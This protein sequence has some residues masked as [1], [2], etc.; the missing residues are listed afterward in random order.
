ME[1]LVLIGG[2]GHA[3]VVLDMAE[4]CAELEVVGYFDRDA[5]TSAQL[6]APF[7]G[8]VSHLARLAAQG[9]RKV[10]IAIGDNLLRSQLAEMVVGQGFEL[11]NIVSRHAM[12]SRR[13]ELCTGIAVMPGAIINAYARIGEGCV[14]NTGATVDHDCKI[15]AWA[16]LGPQTGLAGGVEVG[17][18]T[19]M[20]VGVRVIPRISI[21]AWTTVGAGAVVVR[22]L[23]ERVLAVGV[24]ARILR[25]LE[26][27]VG[28]VASG[29]G[30][31]SEA[32]ISP[33]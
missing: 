26:P 11:V 16:H 14:I 15:G 21:G 19:Y 5:G 31:A 3:K 8:D 23:P 25:R 29:I 9:I 7:L 18:G 6:P 30:C 10:F 4:D 32:G 12:V 33:N 17:E 13:A 1:K 24:P 2:G 22:N 28:R 27:Q 20:G